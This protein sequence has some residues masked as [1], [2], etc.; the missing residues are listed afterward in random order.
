MD[1]LKLVIVANAPEESIIN[2]QI[3]IKN[4]PEKIQKLLL[5]ALENY[6][7]IN[8]I[9]AIFEE[10]GE[11]RFKVI[12]V[13]AEL[14]EKN[15]LLSEPRTNLLVGALKPLK[16]FMSER[17]CSEGAPGTYG[18]PVRCRYCNARVENDHFAG[19]PSIE[20]EKLLR[21]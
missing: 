18:A 9:T 3:Q 1:S 19:C 10:E 15:I 13:I 21:E 20:Y 11:D 4:L 8:K 17:R 14:P 2:S 16:W 7:G 12:S 5:A 6:F